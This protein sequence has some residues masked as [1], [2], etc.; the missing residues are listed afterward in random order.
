[1][2]QNEKQVSIGAP[3]SPSKVESVSA[4]TVYQIIYSAGGGMGGSLWTTY[5]AHKIDE[6]ELSKPFIRVATHLS[7]D[8]L[9]ATN[10][11][12]SVMPMT[13]VKSVVFNKGHHLYAAGKHEFYYIV[14][15]VTAVKASNGFEGD[16]PEVLA[17]FEEGSSKPKFFKT[18][19]WE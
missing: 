8:A 18:A 5:T 2:Y 12:V 4:E 19:F 9:I 13:I 15:P 10:R 6:E 16:M 7:D 11:I 14:S 1:M 3:F 17:H